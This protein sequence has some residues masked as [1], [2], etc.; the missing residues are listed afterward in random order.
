MFV[1]VYLIC[2]NNLSTEYNDPRT[3]A[4]V[5]TDMD[6]NSILVNCRLFRVEFICKVTNFVLKKTAFICDKHCCIKRKE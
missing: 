5:M 6:I 3:R 1:W 2:I 4:A